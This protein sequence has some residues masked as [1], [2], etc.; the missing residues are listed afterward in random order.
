[1]FKNGLFFKVKPIKEYE[2]NIE[3]DIVLER[4]IAQNGVCRDED[5]NGLP[6]E[7]RCFKDGTF[8]VNDTNRK[9]N[10]QFLLQGELLSENGKTK[11]KVD[12][13]K[14]KSVFA[15]SVFGYVF[16]GVVI[17]AGVVHILVFEPNFDAL[18]L[19]KYGLALVVCGALIGMSFKEKASIPVDEK[20]MLNE[21]ER[22]I[23]GV[24]RWND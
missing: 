24:I 7:F 13:V 22:R 18:L 19:S 6:I 14:D 5:S 2:L 8:W 21:I 4:L 15:F 10:R 12:S 16:L 17:L 1:M 20:V 9:R 3:R 11:I 23:N